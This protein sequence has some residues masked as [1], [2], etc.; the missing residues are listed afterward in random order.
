MTIELYKFFPTWNVSDPSPPCI[1]VESFMRLHDIEYTAPKFDPSY[2]KKSPTGRLPF[3][4]TNDGEAISDSSLIIKH[5]STTMNINPHNGLNEKDCARAH[6]F[7]SM[8]DET[9]YYLMVYSRWADPTG[10][11]EVKEAFFAPVPSLLR[12]FI[13]N[14]QRKKALDRLKK[15]G[16][17]LNTP[18]QN[19]GIANDAFK[20]LSDLLG[21]DTWFFNND[22]P[23]LL[24]IICHAYVINLTNPP[25]E[26]DLKSIASQYDN[27]VKHAKKFQDLV[28]S[29]I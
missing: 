20:A 11:K 17:G 15:Q 13:A 12:N 21:K 26:T 4:V 1:K 5:L 10:W 24:D 14:T 27:L 7:C 28:Y 8:L 23:T 6:A 29:D 19:S 25:I 9:I 18:N 22:K 2:F 16:F 3:I